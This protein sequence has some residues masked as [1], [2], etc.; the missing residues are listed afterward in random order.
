MI[1]NVMSNKNTFTTILI[2]LLLIVL[3]VG[4]TACGKSKVVPKVTSNNVS[5]C[6]TDDNCVA[7]LGK[8]LKTCM[9]AYCTSG[10]CKTRVTPNCCG[11]NITEEIENGLSGNKCTCP[12]DYGVCNATIKYT[13]STGRPAIA[14]YILRKCV[15]NECKVVYDDTMQRDSEFFYIWLGAGFTVNTYITYSNPFYGDNNLLQITMKL[16]DYEET[17]L[18]PPIIITEIRLMEGTKILAKVNPPMSLSYIEQVSNATINV[19]YYDFIYPEEPKSLLLSIDYEYV[20]LQA[21]T[22]TTNGKI[23]TTYI[24]LPVERKTQVITLADKITFLDKS[25]VDQ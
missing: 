24:E 19:K 2:A 6:K 22:T 18:Q 5:Q 14:K 9:T 7:L 13:D 12:K 15:E 20:P 23:T 21:K 10:T 8:T 11:N 4:L 16:K 17:K 1:K 25:L 3:V